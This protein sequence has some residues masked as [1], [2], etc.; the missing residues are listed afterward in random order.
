[1]WRS[2]NPQHQ[3]RQKDSR[4]KT[5]RNLRGAR[6][7]EA[8]WTAAVLLPLLSRRLSATD[9]FNHTQIRL[10][11]LFDRAAAVILVAGQNLSEFAWCQIARSV[12]DCG[13]PSAAF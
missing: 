2:L 10:E 4:S 8:S 13:C 7:R 11:L 6:S 3:K 12:L 9:S 5:C 1:M